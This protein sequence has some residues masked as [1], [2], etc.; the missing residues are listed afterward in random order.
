MKSSGS[1][2]GGRISSESTLDTERDGV[3]QT[4]H[5]ENQATTPVPIQDK[6]T[7][8]GPS[9]DSDAPEAGRTK[10]QT[11]LIMF[12]LCLALFLAALDVTIITTIIPTISEEFKSSQG[13]IWVGGAYLLG[14]AAFVP[15]WGKISDI[16]GRKPIILVAAAI[17]WVGS[18]L[19]GV[20]KSMGMLIA[21][22]AVQGIGGGGLIVLPNIAI[23][24]LFSMRNRGLYFGI[25]GM[26]WSIASAVGPVL[27]GAFASKVSCKILRTFCY[28]LCNGRDVERPLT[29]K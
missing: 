26:V 27:G 9:P 7:M 25:L 13:Y 14:N 18:L 3:L 11:T 5:D 22:R 23:S 20:S 17:F 4:I 12:A 8:T 10:V 6:E 28:L 24:D 16:F 1:I 29:V 19:C 2:P 21:A 15:T